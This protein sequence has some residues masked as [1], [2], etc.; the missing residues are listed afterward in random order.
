MPDDG[1][2]SGGGAVAEQLLAVGQDAG[3]QLG[4]FAPSRGATMRL[5]PRPTAAPFVVLLGS[6][7]QFRSARCDHSELAGKGK[8]LPTNSMLSCLVGLLLRRRGGAGHES[9]GVGWMW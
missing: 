3:R 7:A 9:L 1:K 6:P 8:A 5:L 4:H 2:V